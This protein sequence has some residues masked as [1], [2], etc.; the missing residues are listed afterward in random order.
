MTISMREARG[1][2]KELG[3]TVCHVRRTGEERYSHPRVQ[4]PITVNSR[5]KQATRKLITAL[6]RLGE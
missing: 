6:R 3:G 1:L 2:W 5:R 4:R